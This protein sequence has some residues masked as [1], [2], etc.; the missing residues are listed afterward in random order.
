VLEEQTERTLQLQTLYPKVKQMRIK[1]KQ[2]EWRSVKAPRR[3]SQRNREQIDLVICSPSPSPTTS[4]SD[5]NTGLCQGLVNLAYFLLQG[6][7]QP[8]FPLASD[9]SYQIGKAPNYRVGWT[10]GSGVKL[11]SKLPSTSRG[12]VVALSLLLVLTHGHAMAFFREDGQA[13][14]HQA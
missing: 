9:I 14:K 13:S 5:P 3:T 4:E 8:L 10:P 1:R 6:S 7:I 12:M 2:K 11:A